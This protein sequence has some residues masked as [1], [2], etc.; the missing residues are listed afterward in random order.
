MRIIDKPIFS[1][2]P[3]GVEINITTDK[4]S[5]PEVGNLIESLRDYQ[6]KEY[7]LK[8]EPYITVPSNRVRK[9]AWIL[10]EK[11]AH[12][13]RMSKTE[14]LEYMI[15]RYGVMKLD[16]NGEPLLFK[17]DVRVPLSDLKQAYGTHAFLRERGD[18]Y[19]VVAILKSTTE[20]NNVEF[21]A[22]LDGIISECEE[23]GIEIGKKYE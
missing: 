12:K 2:T 3:K 14:C 6:T 11:I 21:A 1:V 13:L 7:T 4:R 5:L 15:E 19:N 20:M 18:E 23:L 8:A 17:V 10:M 22:F 16:K 9:M